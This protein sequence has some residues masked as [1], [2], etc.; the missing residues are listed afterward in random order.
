M[1]DPKIIQLSHKYRFLLQMSEDDFRDIVVRPLFLRMGMKDG[2]ELCGVDEEG[3]DTLF[4]GSN[5]L[6]QTLLYYVQTK[7]GNL[8]LSSTITK[9]VIIAITQLTTALQTSYVFLPT[10]QKIYP[11]YVILCASGK[12]NRHARQHILSN[13][14]DPRIKFYDKD[15]LIP[16][17][18]EIYPEL[19]LGIDAEKLPYL[20]NLKAYLAQFNENAPLS[21]LIAVDSRLTVVTNELYVPLKINFTE[22]SIRK[23][24][25]KITREPKITEIPAEAILKKPNNKIIILGGPGTG[26]STILKR[27]AY[28]L[29]EQPIEKK[30]ALTLP[31]LL[32]AIDISEK[33]ENLID[34]C[35]DEMQRI[36]CSRKPC[37]SAEDLAEGHLA[38]LIDAL[39][40]ILDPIKRKS[41]LV[42][43]DEFI[44]KYPSCK[45]ILTSRE[46]TYIKNI[47]ELSQYD[48]YRVTDIDLHQAKQIIEKLS[49]RKALPKTVLQEVVRQ[50][51]DIHGLT[52]NPLLV[53][54]F[55]AT[56]ADTRKDIPANITELFKKFTE[57][58]LGRWDSSKG[59][60]QQYYAPLKDFL[61][62]KLA[63][64]MH[65]KGL[66]YIKEDECIRF[67][68]HELELRGQKAKDIDVLIYE[69]IHRSGLF[70]C[71]EGRI[72]FRHL[73]LQEF[74]AGRGI[75]NPSEITELIKH[76]W[77]Q[78]AIVFYFG[79]HPGD[80]STLK[81]TVADLNAIS[82][83]ERMQ[84]IVTIGL[85]VQA[86]YLIE[87]TDKMSFLKGVIMGLATVKN[88][89][90]KETLGKGPNYPLT[91]FLFYYLFGKDAVASEILEDKTKSLLAEIQPECKDEEEAETVQFWLIVGLIECGSV[92]EAQAQIRDFKPKDVRLLLALHLGCFLM[93]FVRIFDDDRRVIAKKICE[94]L[95][96]RIAHLRIKVLDEFKSELL[97]IR[98]DKIRAIEYKQDT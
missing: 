9:N 86:C 47:K 94:G 4:I 13:V 19:W 25:G 59:L 45:V 55:I 77:W 57:M 95:A 31:V 96:P 5:D 76:Q 44:S 66:T 69:I 14:K 51:Q 65:K 7:V 8:N 75:P 22:D 61:L 79:E 43:I 6:R 78:R 56:S 80:S 40:E 42:K 36:A 91:L 29:C 39:D 23:Y 34:L 41:V 70:R 24:K 26:K 60:S 73:L 81:K 85:C 87:I 3:K 53:T 54:V 21:D 63:Y 11:D 84:A 12:I 30:K 27:I 49:K 37:F 74:F 46:Y 62:T 17:I 64:E 35:N 71:M 83:K 18:D 10:K 97:E 16:I 32:R 52:L 98:K 38:I 90:L 72:E 2:R 93:Q 92:E 88:D 20:K 15:D 48:E 82:A 50:L 58:M 28:I 33:E 68:T 1:I 89:F 67:F